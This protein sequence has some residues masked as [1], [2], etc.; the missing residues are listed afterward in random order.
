MVQYGSIARLCRSP[1]G[2]H[3]T[4]T[5]KP[6][7]GPSGRSLGICAWPFGPSRAYVVFPM[8]PAFSTL[9]EY[10]D[11][12]YIYICIFLIF[13]YI[14]TH[15]IS[16]FQQGLKHVVVSRVPPSGRL[17][18]FFS[19]PKPSHCATDSGFIACDSRDGKDGSLDLYPLVS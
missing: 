13:I 10:I 18:S 16:V 1:L 12:M 17:S 7:F 14:Y 15:T 9:H 2:G 4:G 8:P 19:H 11:H 6:P 3:C 5:P